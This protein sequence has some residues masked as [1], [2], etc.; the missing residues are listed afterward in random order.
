MKATFLFILVI[1]VFFPIFKTKAL[2]SYISISE[3]LPD[4]VGSDSGKEYIELFSSSTIHLKDWYFVNTSQS[5]TVKRINLPEVDI[6]A[7]TYFVFAEDLSALGILNGFSLGNGKIALYNDFGKLELYNSNNQLILEVNYGDSKEGNSWENSGPL[8][9]ELDLTTINTPGSKNTNYKNECFSISEPLSYPQDSI[10]LKNIEFSLDGVTWTDTI[11][12]FISTPIYFRYIT[13]QDVILQNISWKDVNGNKLNNPHIFNSSYRNLINFEATYK[14]QLINGASLNIDI[15]SNIPSTLIITE[16]YPSPESPDREWIEIY[17]NGD[18]DVNLINY[19]LEEKSSTGITN[20]RGILKDQI[21]KSREYFVLYEEEFNLSLNNSG[22]SIYIFDTEGKEI[23]KFIY[24]ESEKSKSVGR[25]FNGNEF[26]PET[27]ITLS[28]TPFLENKF[29]ESVVATSELMLF[30]VSDINELKGGTEFILNVNI[31]NYI[32][33]YVFINDITGTLKAKLTKVILDDIANTAVRTKAKVVTSNGVKNIIIN[34][35]D[36]EVIG[37]LDINYRVLEKSSLLESNIGN[38]FRFS[39]TVK[40]V[41]A[42]RYKVEFENELINVY[43]TN[44]SNL[45]KGDTVEV[46]G[47]LDYFRNAYRIIEN[48]RISPEVKGDSVLAVEDRVI[49]K[50]NALIE[51]SFQEDYSKVY[52]VTF[53]YITLGIILMYE[54]IKSRKSIKKFIKTSLVSRLNILRP[55]IKY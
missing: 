49:T 47:T 10:T 13:N 15:Q 37:Y 29:P 26:S 44:T 54:L 34:P 8:C 11:S 39:A 7:D 6:L 12:T 42:N 48:E 36:I 23:D 1:G 50:A 32:D 35:D 14:G 40:E 53:G 4:A 25:K 24:T 41:Y 55:V 2:D 22:D 43:S 3:L 20:N 16:L 46:S 28:P 45:F 19:Y 5:G 51:Q 27:F 31:N 17:N 30:T 52:L 33:K 18:K 9:T 38:Q 21:I